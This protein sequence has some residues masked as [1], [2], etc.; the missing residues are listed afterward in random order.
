MFGR[1]L[2]RKFC[3]CLSV[4]LPSILRTPLSVNWILAVWRRT[5]TGEHT[6]AHSRAQ[7]AQWPLGAELSNPVAL[8][9][10]C[11]HLTGHFLPIK[12]CPSLANL[13]SLFSK[14]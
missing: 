12:T 8:Q 11:L 7:T 5:E 6:G 2:T 3:G 4:T 14:F 9:P 10:A 13:P 1:T